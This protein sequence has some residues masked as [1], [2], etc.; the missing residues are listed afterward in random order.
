MFE[1]SFNSN[2]PALGLNV[3]FSFGARH[4]RR[5]AKIDLG[6]SP[7]AIVHGLHSSRH[8]DIYQGW[9]LRITR[10]FAF[11]LLRNGVCGVHAQQTQGRGIKKFIHT[12]SILS[13]VNY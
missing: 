13:K 6:G 9:R 8:A 12:S 10:A 1:F 2:A 3:G 11:A 5:T 7:V 4:E